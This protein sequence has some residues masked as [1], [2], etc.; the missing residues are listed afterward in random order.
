MRREVL[1]I[2]LAL[3]FAGVCS[4]QR[5]APSE[6]LERYLDISRDRQSGCSD[7]VLAV[8]IDACLP[9]LRKQ[10]SMTGLKLIS[11][12]GQ[13]VYCSLRFTGDNFVKTN[14][15]ARFLAND[16]QT[17]ERTAGTGVTRENYWFTY[18]KTSDYNGL[19]AYVFGLKPK[20]KKVGLFKGELWLNAATATPLRWWGDLIKSPSFFIR[21]FRFVQDYQQL[22]QCFEPLRLLVTVQT[23]IAGEAEM[24]VWLHSVESGA[25]TAETGGCS[26]SSVASRGIEP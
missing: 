25:A 23:R 16:M 1:P 8:Q 7:L 12:T 20:R 18:D 24:T 26:S 22:K 4:A 19:L 14:V 10:G 6:A 2:A 13:S 21:G 17:S 15:I 9:E 11:R 3:V 5:L